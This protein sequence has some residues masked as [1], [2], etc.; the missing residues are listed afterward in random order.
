MN[1]ELIIS[2]GSVGVA[3]LFALLYGKARV[4]AASAGTLRR[5][6]E[7]LLG[8]SK[9]QREV[10][11]GKEEYIRELEKVVLGNLPASELAG[12]LTKLFQG[13]RHREAGPLPARKSG[14][15][16]SVR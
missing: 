11:K 9:S 1:W 3:L 15:G 8:L 2:A 7:D 13:A 12:R 4:E 5:V 6:T 10:V 14:T 16:T